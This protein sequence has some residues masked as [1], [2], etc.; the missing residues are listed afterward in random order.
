MNSN[1][2][3]TAHYIT[4]DFTAISEGLICYKKDWDQK[5]VI[6]G[7]FFKLT[8]VWT[9]ANRV[10]RRFRWLV[11]PPILHHPGPWERKTKKRRG[12]S[13]DT[14]GELC[15]SGPIHGTSVKRNNKK[16]LGTWEGGLPL[17]FSFEPPA[18]VLCWSKKHSQTVVAPLARQRFLGN[19]I[20]PAFTQ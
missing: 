14:C 20:K 10:W 13:I 4:Q 16:W 9:R 12:E 8:F 1:T 18:R 5:V 6:L 7:S 19:R 2:W 11:Q 15:S 17:T 3:Y